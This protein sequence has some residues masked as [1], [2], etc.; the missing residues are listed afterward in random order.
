VRIIRE[1][2]KR[3]GTEEMLAIGVGDPLA[4]RARSESHDRVEDRSDVDVSLARFR[5]GRTRR[6]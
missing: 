6:S 5:I 3:L 4:D 2:L 1:V